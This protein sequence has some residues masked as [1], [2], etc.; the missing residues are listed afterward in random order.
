MDKETDKFDVLEERISQLLEAYS[1]LRDEKVTL[2]ERLAEKELEIQKLKEKVSYLSRER[3][4]AREKVEG[5]L[6]RV[7]RLIS[8]Q[9]AMGK[10]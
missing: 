2:G 7:D 9:V 4:A 6:T 5:L 3:E 8:P 1:T 10:G